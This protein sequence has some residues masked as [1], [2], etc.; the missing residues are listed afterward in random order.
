M[1]RKQSESKADALTMKEVCN[2]MAN[3]VKKEKKNSTP[4]LAKLYYM[5]LIEII[6]DE[7]KRNGKFTLI[8][9]GT[10]ET[11]MFGGFHRNT[12]NVNTKKQ[13]M[14]LVPE[15]IVVKFSPADFIKAYLNNREISLGTKKKIREKINQEKAPVKS[16]E[17]LVK[18]E[19]QLARQ[20]KYE[21]LMKPK[22]VKTN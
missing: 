8:N 13:S 10:F 11:R 9:I 16:R 12:Y 14:E 22:E 20:K 2:M 4:E 19:K 17:A 5:A 7:L 3:L 15:R 6:S 21:E 18:K 1:P